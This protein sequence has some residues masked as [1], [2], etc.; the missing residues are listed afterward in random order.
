MQCVY[1]DDRLPNGFEEQF[2]FSAQ[3]PYTVS[4]KRFPS[5]DIVPLHY[6]ET[7]ELLLCEELC[8]EIVIDSQHFPLGGRQLYVIPPYT[9]HSNNIRPGA[10]TM[11]VFKISFREMDRYFNA[12]NF[13]AVNDLSLGQL[14]YAC[15]EYAAVKAIVDDLIV[16]DGD[17]MSCLTRIPELFLVLARHADRSRD[18]S[19]AHSRFR[20][21]SLQ[22]LIRWTNE[23]YARKITIDEVASMTGYSKYHFCSRFKAQT[24]MTY[25]QYL[26]SVRVSQ[27]C[28]ALRSGDSVQAVCRSCGFENTSHF[29]QTFKKVQHMTPRQYALQ[30][31]KPGSAPESSP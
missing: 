10:G 1:Y 5:E 19:E 17:L 24:G 25:M 23:N 31:K 14:P 9:V 15:P 8:G 11:Y 18:L 13:L 6:A 26:S 30:Q 27:A 4:I 7:I 3:M 20:S 28:L 22:E 29:I 12:A 16:R 2:F 21:S